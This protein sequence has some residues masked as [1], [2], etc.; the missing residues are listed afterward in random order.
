MET[1]EEYLNKFNESPEL[2]KTVSFNNKILVDLMKKA[3]ERGTPLTDDEVYEA[4]EG[5]YDLI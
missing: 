2:P 4:F 3:I 5:K 1:F